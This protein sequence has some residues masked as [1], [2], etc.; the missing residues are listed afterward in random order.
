MLPAYRNQDCVISVPSFDK[1]EKSICGGNPNCS[2]S[3]AQLCRASAGVYG[4]RQKFRDRFER[5]EMG[6]FAMSSSLNFFIVV[7]AFAGFFFC[8]RPVVGADSSTVDSSFGIFGTHSA[9]EF[10]QYAERFGSEEA[11]YRWATRHCDLLGARY[12]RLLG[13]M[14]WQ[15]VEPVPGAGYLWNN[16]VAMTG[17]RGDRFVALVR[18]ESEYRH[19]FSEGSRL[20][21]LAVIDYGAGPRIMEGPAG[22]QS[23]LTR[24]PLRDMESFL[25]FVRASVRQFPYIT[26]WQVGNEDNDWYFSGR[27]EQ[28]YVDFVCKVSEAIRSI[29]PHDKIVLMAPM[30]ADIVDSRMRTVIEGLL[31]SSCRFD[32]L[33]LHHAGPARHWRMPAVQGYRKLLDSYG[34]TDVEIWSGENGTWTGYYG[35]PQTESDQAD[36]LVKRYVYN[37]NNGLDKLFWNNLAE[38]QRF[39][40]REDDPFNGMGLIGDGRGPGER[41]SAPYAPRKAYFAYQALAALIDRAYALPVGPV[42]ECDG[43]TT[44]GYAYREV[45]SGEPFYIFW[46]DNGI[47]TSVR[48]RPA[49]TAFTSVRFIDYALGNQTAALS[50]VG[51][52]IQLKLTEFPTL[53]LSSRTAHLPRVING[54]PEKKNSAAE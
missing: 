16:R 3:I 43:N 46:A 21:C 40:G 4:P 8:A 27:T 39:G 35:I 26:A 24:Q 19:V 38:W 17:P 31:A 33:D 52:E 6:P 53:V 1:F 23:K 32:A 15:L 28:Q 9:R 36:S 10:P 49:G 13:S 45:S 29:D 7:M 37:L 20:K 42:P 41:E 25:Q 54:G 22:E 34:L 51:D 5:R 14:V 12:T 11:F 50:H 2:I 30:G 44:H 47:S 48:F 18:G